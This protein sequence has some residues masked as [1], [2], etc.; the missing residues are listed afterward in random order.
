MSDVNSKRKPEL[1]LPYRQWQL[2]KGGV[3]SRPTA[4]GRLSTV[5]C[6]LSTAYCLP[7]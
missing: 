1:E 2:N 7:F 3:D 6:L 5:Y 4:I